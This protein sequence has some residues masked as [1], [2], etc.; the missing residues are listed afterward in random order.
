MADFKYKVYYNNSSYKVYNGDYR[1]AL[2]M[3]EQDVSSK[4]PVETGGSV[5]LRNG[6]GV[7]VSERVG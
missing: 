1:Y 6:G 4:V 3:Y 5:S 7:F 2:D